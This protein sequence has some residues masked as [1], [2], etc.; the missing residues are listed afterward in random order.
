MNIGSRAL[1]TVRSIAAAVSICLPLHAPCA[2]VLIGQTTGITGNSAANTRET[3]AGAQLW[4]DHINSQG[5]VHGNTIRILAM[6]DRGNAALAAR[7]ARE[8]IEDRSVLALFM[9]RGTPQNEA[10]LPLLDRYGVPS[11]APSTGAMLLHRPVKRHV[12]NVRSPYQ[13]EA[14]R[15]IAQLASMGISRIAVLQTR[16]SFGE[17]TVQGVKRGMQQVHLAPLF[18][19][20]FDK[21]NPKFEAAAQRVLAQDAQAVLVVGTIVSVVRATQAIRAV[22]SRATVVTLSNNA[23]SSLINELGDLAPGVVVSQV[24]PSERSA[25]VPMIHEAERLLH[26]K[27]PDAQLSPAMIEGFAA[28]KVLV[29]AVR[30]AGAH[31]S[32]ASLQAALESMDSY[33]LGGLVLHYSADN[34]TGLRYTDLSIIDKARTFRR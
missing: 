25:A 22:G 19:D 18:I 24:F 29:E 6:D 23:S 10:V 7:N 9:I 34:H 4:L 27:Q 30:R 33:D 16:D 14:E 28:A 20:G 13:D 1:A 32:R 15:C 26:A 2:E 3:S 5:G 31:A 12:F 11:I 17:D 21:E 8:L